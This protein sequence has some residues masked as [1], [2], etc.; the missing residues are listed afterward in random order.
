MKQMEKNIKTVEEYSRFLWMIVLIGFGCLVVGS[1]MD[2]YFFTD[3]F[4]TAIIY[5]TSRNR[6][7]SNFMNL[8]KMQIKSI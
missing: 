7:S 8:E 4:I 5:V 2:I 6:A 3:S 1:V